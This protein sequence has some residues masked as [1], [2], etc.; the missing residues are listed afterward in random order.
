MFGGPKF[1]SI[2]DIDS[3]V[4][5]KLYSLTKRQIFTVF[6]CFFLAVATTILIGINGPPVVYSEVVHSS[7]MPH[8]AKEELKLDRG[9][10]FLDSPYLSSFNQQLYLWCQILTNN[11]AS[12]GKYSEPFGMNV[13]ILGKEDNN[14]GYE[15]NKD[16]NERTRLLQC[17]R[18]TCSEFLVMHLGHLQYLLYTVIV[19]FHSLNS[20]PHPIREVIFTWQTFNPNFTQL[21]IWF[22]FGFLVI[23][24]A[25]ICL[26]AHSM[27]KF[28]IKDWTIE[29]KWIVILLPLLLLYNNPLFAL[30][31][32]VSSWVPNLFD[33]LF[34]TSFCGALLM[35]WV[36][37]YHGLRTQERGVCLFYIPKITLVGSIWM[38]A[39][40]FASWES[41]HK[42]TDPTYS[43]D[44]DFKN[45][46]P[47]RIVF[48]VALGVYVLYL[49]F[50]IIRAW[51]ELT[52][53]PYFDVRLKFLTI[54]TFI[55]IIACCSLLF[56]RYG[57][58]MTDG[59]AFGGGI[60]SRYSNAAEFLS[61]YSILNFYVYT[62]AFVYSPAKNAYT[63]GHFRDNPAFSM[64][65]DESDDDVM[66][67]GKSGA[68]MVN[69]QRMG[70]KLMSDSD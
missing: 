16:S 1:R 23:T 36:C 35:F 33:A 62:L 67:G 51:T 9:P 15:V 3:S 55:I 63:D 58:R 61:L 6:S 41:Y 68:G 70:A 27:R 26:F 29:Q 8:I 69:G 40:F 44:Y 39:L 45:Y 5:M 30:T 52:S 13:K 25:A 65:N 17:H 47:L 42:T 56:I 32:L 59:E 21:E 4:Q 24:F 12:A 53:L 14:Y 54:L 22:R 11:S 2:D 31:F 64:L 38:L 34:Q 49:L 46:T 10:F 19:Q 18:D 57:L 60:M 37:T 7:E 20:L 48:F 43:T 28:S 66:Y 50:L